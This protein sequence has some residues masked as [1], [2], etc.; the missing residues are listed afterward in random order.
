I[1][2]IVPAYWVALSVLAVLGVVSVGDQ[3]WRYYLFLQVYSKE[4]ILG[5]IVVAGSLCTEMVFYFV[6]PFLGR[7]V[8]RLTRHR[9]RRE[10]I[11]I[12]FAFCAVL[13]A[14]GILSRIAVDRWWPSER[15]L[16]FTWLPQNF[17][18]FA[19]GMALAALS[20]APQQLPY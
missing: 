12:N 8:L 9:P 7:A 14:T 5:G 15:G 20:V 16:A 2:R 3:P 13:F 19:T 11:G 10:A 4:T 17:D 18:L 1:L 6:L